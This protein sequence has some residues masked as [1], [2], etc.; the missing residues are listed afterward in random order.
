[1]C[2]FAESSNYGT[3]WY[4]A[5]LEHERLVADEWGQLS[6]TDNCLDRVQGEYEPK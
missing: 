4:C 3:K 2:R 1:M 5:L 6:R